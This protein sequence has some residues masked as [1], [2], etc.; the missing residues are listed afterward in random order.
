MRCGAAPRPLHTPP[1]L[2]GGA[3]PLPDASSPSPEAAGSGQAF[4]PTDSVT[5]LTSAAQPPKPPNRQ[6]AVG[7]VVAGPESPKASPIVAWQHEGAAASSQLREGAVQTPPPRVA[8]L[9]SLESGDSVPGDFRSERHGPTSR[10]GKIASRGGPRPVKQSNTGQLSV[11]TGS[12]ST[13]WGA[14]RCHGMSPKSKTPSAGW[15]RQ[16]QGGMARVSRFLSPGGGNV[17]RTRT[18]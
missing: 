5:E 15:R 10:P 14:A 13:S 1:P 16:S 6:D 18:D 4:F 17:R 8:A 7:G 3:P 11:A 12:S 2:A 9:P